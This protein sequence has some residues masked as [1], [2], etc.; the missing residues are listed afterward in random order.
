MYNIGIIG[1]GIVGTATAESFKTNSIIN[2]IYNYDKFKPSENTI[3]ETVENSDV[4]FVCVPTPTEY[5]KQSIDIIIDVINDISKYSNGSII[6]IRSTVLPGTCRKLSNLFP[7]H[8][9]IACPEF[10]TE[11]NYLVECKRPNRIIIG[12]IDDEYLNIVYQLHI[13]SFETPIFICSWEESEITKYASNI[14]LATKVIFSNIIYSNC[15]FLN[16]DWETV[17]KMWIADPRIGDSHTSVPG[18]DGKRGYA[19][20]CFPKDIEAFIGWLFNNHMDEYCDFF[21]DVEKINHLV[22]N[23][24]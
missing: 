14:Y 5:Y 22:R 6:V 12:G 23:N 16:A 4:L 24:I 2:K 18:N 17:R 11:K 21:K 10:L 7:M 8:H 1:C 15:Q 20:T 9:I 3:S 13:H 19:G